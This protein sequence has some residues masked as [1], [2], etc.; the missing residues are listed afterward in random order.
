LGKSREA[1]SWRGEPAP[2]LE[3]DKPANPDEDLAPPKGDLVVGIEGGSVIGVS[4]ERFILSCTSA[5]VVGAIFKVSKAV[6]DELMGQYC[7][8]SSKQLVQKFRS[9]QGFEL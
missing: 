9:S 2:P 6:V 3:P 8:L 7:Q 4:A 5:L 1:C